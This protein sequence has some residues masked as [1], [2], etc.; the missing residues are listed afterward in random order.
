MSPARPARA[1]E[2]SVLLPYRDAAETLGEALE[3]TLAD[4][5][6]RIELLAVDDGSEDAGP[7]LVAELA[8]RDAR[9]RPSRTGGVGIVGALEHA[10]RQARAPL[11]ARMDGDDVT[12]PGRFGAQRRALEANDRLGAV[13]ARVEAFAEGGALGGG[14]R[15]YVAWQNGLEGARAHR[16]A[17]FVEA[18]LCHPSTMIRADALEAVGGYRHGDFPE[19]Y[20][21]WLRLDAGGWALDKVGER[22]VRWRH[23][24][25]RATFT[26]PRYRPDAMRDVKGP[27]LAE[28][29]RGEA[30]P[31]AVWGAGR[32]GRRAMRAFEAYGLAAAKWVDIDP[33]KI[34]RT[35]RGAPIVG[36]EALTRD[37]FTLVAVGARGARDEVRRWLLGRG[38]V[39]G[40][41]FLC[42]S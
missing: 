8:R 4:S 25:G 13:G 42:V 21:L 24:A 40:D 26:D 32:T 10:R 36:R 6:A 1:P 31:L 28:R 33:R 27:Y 5:S 11:L 2:V 38:F 37:E 12:L 15:A 19:D 20:E 16:D 7:A 9:V 3:S 18:P 30:R 17:L 34:G 39:E 29:L 35:A 41:D 22:L 14:M 23:T